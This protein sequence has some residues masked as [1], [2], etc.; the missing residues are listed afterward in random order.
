[1]LSSNNKF[2]IVKDGVVLNDKLDKS[3]CKLEPFFKESNHIAYVTSGIRTA[4]KQL[5]II[6]DF[7]HNKKISDEFTELAK[8]ESKVIYAGGEIYSWQLAWSKLLNAGVIINP[9]LKAKLLLDYINKA[10]KNRKGDFFNPSVHFSGK[11]FDIGG[12][13]NSVSDEKEIVMEAI[14]SGTCLEIVSFVVERENNC[15]HI[16]VS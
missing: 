16:N 12:G 2:L 6:K 10:G 9:P 11:A 3:I 8:V 14:K 15:L 5:Q 4:E 13:P 1:M 7:I